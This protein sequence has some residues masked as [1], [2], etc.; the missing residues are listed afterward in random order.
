M[1]TP[2]TK[3][4]TT[5]A[6]LVTTTEPSTIVEDPL[7]TPHSDSTD[8]K[9]DS[10]KLSIINTTGV[11]G[12][13]KR[14]S[15]IL[16]VLGYKNITLGTSNDVVTGTLVKV[17]KALVPYKDQIFKDLLTFKDVKIHDTLPDSSPLDIVIILGK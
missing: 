1:T 4:P 10:Y 17:K 7:K 16:G 9:R 8:Y 3:T 14:N 2:G 5:P 12:L 11:T 6:V 15:E 13:A